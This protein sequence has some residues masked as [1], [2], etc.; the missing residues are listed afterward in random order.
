MDSKGYG[1]AV[2]AY[3]TWGLFPLYW[4]WLD[5]VSSLQ[6][7]GHRMV[8]SFVTLLAIVFISRQWNEF[9]EAAFDRRVIPIYAAAGVL[10]ALNWLLFVWLVNTGHIVEISLGYFINP[11]VSILLGVVVLRERLRAGQWAAI[12]LAAVGIVCLTVAYGSLPW[13][14][15]ALGC[16][17]GLYG[18]VKKVAPLGVLHGLTLETGLLLL[19]ALAYLFYEDSLRR[20]AFLHSGTTIDLLLLGAGPVTTIPLLLFAAAAKRIPLS[21][22]GLFQYITPTLQ[23]LIGVLVYQETFT[24]SR[25]MGFAIV[26]VALALS[27]AESF[28][29]S[30]SLSSGSS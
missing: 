10:I 2:A 28:Y 9:R 27:A 13:A 29:A 16:T 14:S 7:I 21:M 22:V 25:L 26:W 19:P 5:H 8:W 17:F 20:A 4:K 6:V 1:Y 24:R 23:F 15:L 3:A 11:L 12:A 18:L 30:A